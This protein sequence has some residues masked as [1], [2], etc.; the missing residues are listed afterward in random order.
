MAPSLTLPTLHGGG[1][2]KKDRGVA[3]VYFY[4]TPIFIY[5]W[6]TDLGCSLTWPR[7]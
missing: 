5:F 7:T 6:L 3:P 2:K 1:N 4:F